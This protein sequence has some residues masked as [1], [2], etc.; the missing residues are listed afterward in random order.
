MWMAQLM[1]KMSIKWFLMSKKCKTHLCK[2]GS[3]EDDFSSQFRCR[4][5]TDNEFPIFV[6]WTTTLAD[7]DQAEK[8]VFVLVLVLGLKTWSLGRIS[9]HINLQIRTVHLVILSIGLACFQPLARRRFPKTHGLRPIRFCTLDELNRDWEMLLK[10]TSSSLMSTKLIVF[11]ALFTR[12]I[13]IIYVPQVRPPRLPWRK[14]LDK[15]GRAHVWTP[16]TL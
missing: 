14:C 13:L 12:E 10:K 5:K 8:L 16:V 4:R 6:L 2:S 9:T 7:Y 11:R 1:K 3:R 15:I